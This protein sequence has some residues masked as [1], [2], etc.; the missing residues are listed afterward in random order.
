MSTHIADFL[1]SLVSSKL[2]PRENSLC[3]GKAS[4]SLD[5]VFNKH[6]HILRPECFSAALLYCIHIA[7]GPMWLHPS[8][9]HGF[10]YTL[11]RFFT[12]V[13][14]SSAFIWERL[15]SEGSIIN[16]WFLI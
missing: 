5:S 16:F 13:L 8:L 3:G 14:S 9:V 10:I 11:N 15:G 4:D 1:L 7:L 2:S 12:C 6:T